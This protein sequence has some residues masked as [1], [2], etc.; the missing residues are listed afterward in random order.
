MWFPIIKD[1]V[2]QNFLSTE[3][4][5]LVIDRTQDRVVVNLLVVSLVYQ[6]RSTPI[7]MT[8]LD[9]KGNSNCSKNCKKKNLQKT[10]NK[11]YKSDHIKREKIRIT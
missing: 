3:L 10:S 5:Y 1:L 6:S 4:S 8:N 9:K 11:S 2:N 7:Y